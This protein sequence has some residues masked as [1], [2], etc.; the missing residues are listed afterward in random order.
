V[1]KKTDRLC[2]LLKK[3]LGGENSENSKTAWRGQKINSE[4]KRV[5]P[6]RTFS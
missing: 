4:K 2:G 5:S 3:I 6:W 1:D